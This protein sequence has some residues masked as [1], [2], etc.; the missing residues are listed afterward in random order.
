M[1]LPSALRSTIACCCMA[2]APLGPPSADAWRATWYRLIEEGRLTGTAELE[3]RSV[4]YGLRLDTDGNVIEFC[5]DEAGVS[6]QLAASE[7]RV[8]PYLVTLRANRALRP[9][10]APKL[11]ELPP[12]DEAQCS[13]CTGP[14][15]LAARPMVAQAV[16]PSTERVWDVH[17]NVAPME[18]TGHFLLVPDISKPENR[19]QQRLT[20]ADCVDLVELARAL[21]DALCV[22]F[23][24][25]RAGASQNHIH[26]HAW[27]MPFAYPVRAAAV[28]ARVALPGGVDDEVAEQLDLSLIHI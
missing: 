12:H 24:A 5:E 16:V 23:N 22:N 19:R 14:L 3:D 17:F 25:A 4:A 28:A 2:A 10:A 26:I 21:G 27:A 8:G 9:P 6:L 1:H 11:G 20:R 15:R 18:P 13:M 7:A